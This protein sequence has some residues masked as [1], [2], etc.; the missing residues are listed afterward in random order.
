MSDL[1]LESEVC[2]FLDDV[3]LGPR[4]GEGGGGLNTE[5]LAAKSVEL[6]VDVIVLQRI[7]GP[8]FW[9]LAAPL[10]PF[11]AVP[12]QVMLR[13]VGQERPKKSI[14]LLLWI[15]QGQSL[16]QKERIWLIWGV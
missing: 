6:G 9:P 4:G 11:L 13:L 8:E 1:C 3:T 2:P 7:P 5:E 14:L 15:Q 12:G 10:A 16:S